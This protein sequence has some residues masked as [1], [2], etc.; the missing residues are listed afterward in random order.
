MNA[1][2]LIHHLCT[3]AV[4]A[5]FAALSNVQASEDDHHDKDD[6]EVTITLMEVG[7]HHGTLVPRLNLRPGDSVKGTEGGLARMARV[8]KETRKEDPEALLFTAGDTLQG[9]AE[10]LYSSGQAIVDVL[11]TFNIDAYAPGNWDWLYGK[12]RFLEL[13]GDGRWGVTAAN[14][15]HSDTGERIFPAYRILNVKGVKIG[16][17]GMT[18]VRGLPLV[19]AANNG[20]TFTDGEAELAENI[21]ILRN[22]EK[23]DIVIL[24][25]ELGLA[26]NTLLVEKYPG[27]DVLFSSDMHEEAPE[28]IITPVNKVLATEIGWGGSRLAKLELTVKNGKI[29]DHDYEWIPLTD[30]IKE[31]KATAIKVR[32]VRAAFV[33]GKDFTPHINPINGAVL[34]TPIDAP[35]G[36]TQQTLYR[37]NFSDHPHLPGVIEGSSHDFITDAFRTQGHADIAMMRGFR[38]GTYLPPGPVNRADLYTYLNAGAQVATGE[39]PGRQI[40][41]LLENNIHGTLKRDP[42]NWSGG[43]IFSFSGLRY[44]IDLSLPQGQRARNVQVL[45]RDSET[46]EPLDFAQRYTVAGFYFDLTPN[47]ISA[48]RNAANVKVLRHADGSPK[49]AVDVVADYLADHLADPETGRIQTLQPLP[50]PVFGNPE[51]Q[52]LRGA[53]LD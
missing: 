19:P 16:L 46:W 18:S 39:V 15:Y 30:D 4:L 17:I 26:A 28:L 52:P 41:M 8:I 40:K 1:R 42:L 27:V 5:G 49:D 48:L 38:F 14:V 33:Q 32:K 36:Y 25:S 6:D 35:V 20:L 29:V 9:G 47:N 3:L 23:V 11:D 24:L 53:V 37:G 2:K 12:E 45:R 43:W 10:V 7:D 21:D 44:Q 22:R 50:A 51:M 31:D 34:D 13:F